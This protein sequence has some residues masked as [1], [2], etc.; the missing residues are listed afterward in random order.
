MKLTVITA[1]EE[2]LL[3]GETS[4]CNANLILV[5]WLVFVEVVAVTSSHLVGVQIL[6]IH[7]ES[8]VPKLTVALIARYL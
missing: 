7:P 2:D 4:I 5:E 3:P 6:L 8:A 1:I